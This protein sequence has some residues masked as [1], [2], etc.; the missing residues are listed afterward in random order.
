[1]M[2]AHG[3]GCDQNMW[4][5][6]TPAF[7]NE[8]KIVLFDFL[9]C[10]DSDMDAFKQENYP[11]LNEYG[12]D[13]L[14]IITSLKLSNVVLVGHSVGSMIGMLAAIKAPQLFQHVIMVSPSPCY[15]NYH[16]YKG[17]FEK[18]EIDGLLAKLK[19]NLDEWSEKFAPVI[20][21]NTDRPALTNE[22]KDS[23]KSTDPKALYHFAELTFKSDLRCELEKLK[24]PSLVM[25]CS[26]DVIAPTEV[27]DFLHSHLAQS[28][29]VVLKASG[30][31]AHLSEPEETIGFIKA[32]LAGTA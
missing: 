8:Y 10:G 6:I 9:G 32:Y 14:E 11:S 20:M 21:S 31:C 22:L 26:E 17:G 5:F 1:M 7:E 4:R 29:L 24:V 16:G 30:H 19:E 2:F 15:I 12:D 13:I 3:L 27:G 18:V 23:F 25:Q 28:Q